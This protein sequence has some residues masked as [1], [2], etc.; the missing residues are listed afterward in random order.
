[1]KKCTPPLAAPRPRSSSQ[2]D[3]AGPSG[4]YSQV[5]ERGQ[6]SSASSRRGRCSRDAKE[7]SHLLLRAHQRADSRSAASSEAVQPHAGKTVIAIAHRLS[8]SLPWT[9]SSVTP[10]PLE[11]VTHAQLLPRALY[12]RLWVHSGGFWEKS[13]PLRRARLT[14]SSAGT[15]ATALRPHCGGAMAR[16]MLR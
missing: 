6:A 9:G 5:G 12:A 15:C 11:E 13:E 7:R 1:M 10:A 16:P 4:Y 3:I 2:P 14:P 8:P